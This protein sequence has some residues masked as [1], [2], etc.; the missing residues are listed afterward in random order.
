MRTGEKSFTLYVSGAADNDIAVMN[1]LSGQKEYRDV[2][3]AVFK[4]DY[5]APYQDFTAIREFQCAM[6]YRPFADKAWR[7][8][9][10]IV[11]LSEWV[12]HEKE[13]YLEIFCKFLHDFRSFFRLE[14]VFTAG[15]ADRDAAQGLYRLIS[16]Y[17]C[18]GRLVEDN[19]LTDSRAL[20]ELLKETY[21]LDEAVAEKLAEIFTAGQIRGL[22]Q[23]HTVMEDFLA[24]MDLAE[25][26]RV[27]ETQVL[28]AMCSLTDSKLFLLYEDGMKKWQREAEESRGGERNEVA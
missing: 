20:G 18:A 2:P 6:R 5:T 26:R 8:K 15:T 14:Y 4:L 12:G 10:A 25:G 22:T 28:E 3:C 24:R 19:T 11:D 1:Y 7:R 21:P 27:T 9:V 17:L 23:L 13:D 16:E